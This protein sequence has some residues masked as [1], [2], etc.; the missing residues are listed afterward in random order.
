M[1]INP[2]I[3]SIIPYS[4]SNINNDKL[5]AIVSKSLRID[6]RESGDDYDF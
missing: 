5:Y 1:K 6:S 2:R 3:I 4:K